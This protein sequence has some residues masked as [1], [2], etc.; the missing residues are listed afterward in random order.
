MNKVH[1]LKY[2]H[3][4]QLVPVSEVCRARKRGS[5]TGST[6]RARRQGSRAK[7]AT[8]LPLLAAALFS[9]A[10]CASY[11]SIDI[12]YQTYRDFAENKGLSSPAPWAFPS[13]TRTARCAAIQAPPSHSSIF[14]ASATT[15]PLKP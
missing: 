14:P 12:P 11:V 8:A 7:L 2:N 4:N 6:R 15:A 13:S 9:A 3:Q 5:A 1:S 10:A